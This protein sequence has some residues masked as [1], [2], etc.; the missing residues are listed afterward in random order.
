MGILTAKQPN[1][2]GDRAQPICDEPSENWV[3]A[4]V[5]PGLTLAVRA[6]VVSAGLEFFFREDGNVERALDGESV[7][8]K[9]VA[10][11]GKTQAD[12][13]PQSAADQRQRHLEFKVLE[14][15]HTHGVVVG[16]VAAGQVDSAFDRAKPPAGNGSR[17]DGQLE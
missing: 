4:I 9:T 1:R 15:G 7:E 10:P 2:S 16:N 5:H 12:G 17:V 13:A 3:M 11:D 8:R 14:K 6:V